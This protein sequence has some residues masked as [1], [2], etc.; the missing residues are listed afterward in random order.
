MAGLISGKYYALPSPKATLPT[1]VSAGGLLLQAQFNSANKPPTDFVTLSPQAQS[2]L[3][4]YTLTGSQR[5]QL[6]QIVASYKDKAITQDNFNQLQAD[7][8][9]AGIAPS[10]LAGKD[11][12]ASFNPKQALAAAFSGRAITTPGLAS[13]QL[14]TDNYIRQIYAQ[15]KEVST[16][17]DDIA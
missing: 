1:R 16:A 7:L 17:T 5:Q 11:L 9:T 15:W 12:T 8:K 4:N 13:T 10:Q 3:S 6:N 14:K 2:Y